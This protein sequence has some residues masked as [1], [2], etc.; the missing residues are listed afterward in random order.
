MIRKLGLR[1]SKRIAAETG[2]YKSVD[3]YHYKQLHCC[4]EQLEEVWENGTHRS[5]FESIGQAKSRYDH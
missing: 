2:S 5:D 4:Y 1:V 3:V